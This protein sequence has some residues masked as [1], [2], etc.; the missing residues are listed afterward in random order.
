MSIFDD[1]FDIPELQAYLQEAESE[2]IP[3]MKESAFAIT[4]A[5]DYNEPDINAVSRNRGSHPARQADHYR[6]PSR[7]SDPGK[8]KRIP[9]TLMCRR[10][11]KRPCPG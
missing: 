3:K 8:F 2:M 6:Q 7:E 11:Y 1:I 5:T 10:S 4:V 9:A